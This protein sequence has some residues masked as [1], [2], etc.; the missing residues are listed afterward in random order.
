M[1]NFTSALLGKFQAALTIASS[2]RRPPRA[3]Q[4]GLKVDYRAVWT[5]VHEEGLSYKKR[6]WS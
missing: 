6:R 2:T 5:F 4:R 3:M 1:G